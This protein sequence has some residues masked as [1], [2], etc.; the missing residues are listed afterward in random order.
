MAVF[1]R[2]MHPDIHSSTIYNSQN[3][4]A[5]NPCPHHRKLIK[6]MKHMPSIIL[7]SHKNE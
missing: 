2:Y 7:F 6:D 5:T 1:K 3:M 4:K